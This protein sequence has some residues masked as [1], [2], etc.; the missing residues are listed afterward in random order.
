VLQPGLLLDFVFKPG[1]QRA[2]QLVHLGG[3]RGR[4]QLQRVAGVWVGEHGR[5]PGLSLAPESQAR[6]G[7]DEQTLSLIRE[8]GTANES[9]S[10]KRGIPFEAIHFCVTVYNEDATCTIVE[11]TTSEPPPAPLVP[12]PRASCERNYAASSSSVRFQ[13]VKSS[14]D[15]VAGREA[16]KQWRCKP[17]TTSAFLG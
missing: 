14:S 13:L 6:G 4:Q 9:R 3:A 2:E 10:V 11:S 1:E 16:V 8:S 12:A 15:I 17:L 7:L 5:R